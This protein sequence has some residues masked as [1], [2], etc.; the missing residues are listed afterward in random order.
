MNPLHR[1]TRLAAIG[2]LASTC[3]LTATTTVSA[4]PASPTIV[5]GTAAS[6]ADHPWTVSLTLQGGKWC[7]G[8]LVAPTKVVTAAHCTEGY[9]ASDFG[10]IAGRT[11][12]RTS[13]GTTASVTK[14]W[15]HPDYRGADAGDDVSV[16]T[17]DKAL[18]Y[19][20]L[21]LP[22][23]G[24][25]ALYAPGTQ[26]TTLGWGDVKE[27][28]PDSDTLRKVTVPVTT[29]QVCSAAYNSRYVADKMVCAGLD[30][31][32]KDSC[33]GDSGG[34]LTTGGKLVGIVSWGDGCARAK[35]PGVYTRVI[36]YLDVIN[37][38][39]R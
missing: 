12:L 28:G 13:E 35:T 34:P 20:T 30:A 27:G 33:Q 7:G 18:P 15:Q 14:L 24:D 38:Q 1:V 25:T 4:A 26:V 31:G 29:D 21:P 17:L 23:A 3:V 11:D 16:L 6:T 37:A 19:K 9:G 5:G 10:V 39:L 8:T 2:L 32:G 36:N 22:S